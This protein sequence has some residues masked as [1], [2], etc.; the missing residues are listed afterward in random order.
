MSLIEGT[1]AKKREG[2]Q[3]ITIEPTKKPEEIRLRV[4][5]YARVSSDSD[6]QENS[7]AAQTRYYTDHIAEM[8]QWDLVDI[9]ADDGISGT[10]AEKRTDFQRLMNDCRRGLVDRILVKSISRFARNTPECLQAVRE[11]REMGVSV[12]FEKENI[13]T[14]RISSE[15][16]L[17]VFSSFAQQESESISGNMNWAWRVRME[18]GTFVPNSQPF[19]YYLDDGHIAVDEAKA[20]YVRKIFSLYLSGKSTLDIAHYMAELADTLP[21]L[22]NIKWTYK[23]VTRIL[24]NEKYTGN[25]LWQKRFTTDD[26]PHKKVKNRGERQQYYAQ[27]THPQIIDQET[28]DRAQVLM[29][30]QNR[31]KAPTPEASHSA[32]RGALICGHCGCLL[33]RK[34]IRGVG[35]RTC[36]HR[37]DGNAEC[38]LL[39]IRES[40]MEELFCRVYYKLKHYPLLS[41]MLTDLRKVSENRMLWREDVIAL[42]KKMSDIA[43]QE[44]MLASLKKQGLI[45][46]DIFIAQSNNLARE[47][48]EIKRKKERIL[49]GDSDDTIP[50][51]Q[52]MTE[53]LDN[54][55]SFLENF[56]PELFQGLVERITA[57]DNSHFVIRLKNG[58][59]LSETLSLED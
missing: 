21:E 12:Y 30:K 40:D 39:P 1:S 3:I 41:Q 52:E 55:P 42:N 45:D 38:S 34:A 2:Y 16:M 7:L 18:N 36:R 20:E 31:H 5:A 6:D 43:S 22:Q 35:Y 27:E 37:D 46:P 49:D 32:F 11:L 9:Y 15:M 14:D 58:L 23:G 44:Q 10:S 28:F 51:T 48:R 13:D 59:E 19:G 4:A 8:P 53:V 56:S 25:S 17:T 26:F 24:K 54:G 57:V 50:K 29:S 33:R 47:L